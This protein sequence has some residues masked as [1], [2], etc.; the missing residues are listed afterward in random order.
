MT[1]AGENEVRANC[2]ELNGVSGP[3]TSVNDGR[4]CF[5]SG[6]KTDKPHDALYWRFGRQMAV[7]NYQK[8]LDRLADAEGEARQ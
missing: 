1:F 2:N 8:A 3:I 6:E 7:R 4:S 5:I